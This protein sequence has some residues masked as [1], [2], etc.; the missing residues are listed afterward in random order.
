MSNKPRVLF[1]CTHNSARSQMAEAFLCKHGS[2]YFEAHSAGLEPANIHPMTLEVMQEVGFDLLSDGHRSKGLDEYFM[3]VHVGYLI[4]VCANAEAKCPIFPGITVREYWGL[5]DPAA[6]EGTEAE[7][8]AKFR[9]IRDEIEDRVRDF[10]VR[11]TTNA[12]PNLDR[13]PRLDAAQPASS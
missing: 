6:A 13:R 9:E 2:D 1:L 10:I 7:R 11:E 12:D 3:K 5:D 8:L 4:T